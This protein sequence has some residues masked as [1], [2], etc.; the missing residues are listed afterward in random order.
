M[1][2]ELRSGLTA[3]S[4]YW[5]GEADLPAIL[6]LHGFLQT[7]EFQ[8]VRRLA[9]ALSDEG[10]SVLLPSLTLGLDRRR[11]SVACEAIHTH[12][13]QQDVDE[14]RAWIDWL[15]AQRND[16][17][18]PAIAAFPVIGEVLK[19]LRALRGCRLARMSGSGATCFAIFDDAVS[20]DAGDLRE[21]HPDWWVM[22]TEAFRGAF[23][24]HP[25][26]GSAV[27]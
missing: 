6:I 25:A 8:T 22:E 19:E 21:R 23:D 2:L 9:E 13:M 27:S 1:S 20:V 15:A 5:P 26:P 17:E 16:L 4:D 12:S 10:Y 3:V 11:Q 18:A 7:R 14:L 24:L